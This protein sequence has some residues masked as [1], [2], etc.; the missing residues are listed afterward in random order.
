[1]KGKR[2]IVELGTGAD[3]HGEDVTKAACR[4][5]RDA[6]GRSCLC[7]LVEI[8]GLERLEEVQVEILVACP[9]P[10]RVDREAVAAEVP[11]GRKTV[12]VMFG[13]MTAPGLCVDRFAKGCDRIVVANVALT[14][15][16]DSQRTGA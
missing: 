10:D 1:M 7:G 16:V 6:I 4:A 11:I 9:D 14:V 13:G 12:R 3:L 2:F 8:L 5:V 15:S